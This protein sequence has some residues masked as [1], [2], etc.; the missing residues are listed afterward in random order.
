MI[1]LKNNVSY[2]NSW[3]YFSKGLIIKD[4]LKD[5]WSIIVV[6]EK[7]DYAR[8][9]S[10]IFSQLKINLSNIN[11]VSDLLNITKNK[12]WLYYLL[13]DDLD[14]VILNEYNILQSSL[15]VKI[16]QEISEESLIK[17]LND[18]WYSFNEYEKA[19][20]Y[21]KVWDLITIT[22]FSSN[23]LYKINFWGN[24]IEDIWIE[25][26]YEDIRLKQES[27]ENLI[28]WSNKNIYLEDNTE[29][30]NKKKKTWQQNTL[31]EF[32]KDSY[33]VLDYLDFYKNYERHINI[34]ENFSCFDVIWNKSLEIVDLKIN[35]LNI[36]CIEEFKELL[37]DRN[38]EKTIVTKNIKL[39][40]NFIKY[41]NLE[42]IKLEE[43]K[44]NNLKSFQLK[45]INQKPKTILC[46][47]IISKI[48]IKKR[49]NKKLSDNLDLLLKIKAWDFIVHIDHW[50]W[51]F[52]GIVKKQ[53]WD[54]TKEYAEILYKD[55]DK[56]FV[57]ITE[58]SRLSKYVWVDNPKLTPLNTKEWERKIK[59]VSE[60]V[61]IIAE[62][63]LETF[64]KRQNNKWFSFVHFPEKQQKFQS[65]FPYTYTEDQYKII[66]DII[67][68]MSLDKTMDR[69]LVWDVSFW[70]TEIAFN[71]I[72][73]CF[74][75]KKQSVLISPLVVLAYEHY[76]KALDR[77]RWLWMK[78]SVLTRL[79]SVKNTNE[80]LR[81]LREWKIDFI[82]WTHKLLSENTHFKDL[83]LLVI[84]EEHKFWVKDKEKIKKYKTKID[85]LSMSATPIPRSLNMALASI[86]DISILRNPPFWRKSIKTYVSKFSEN[87]IFE[88][89][90]KEFERWWQMFF[91]HNKVRNIDMFRE[92]LQ[93]IFPDK[94]VVITHGQLEW[95]ELEK[96]IIDFKH[97]KYD[98]LL[99]TTV[100]ENGV[101]FPNVNTIFIN[102]CENFGISQIH[103]LRWRVWRTTRQGYCYLMYKSEDI[104][105]EAAK[106]IK[107][108]VE[109]SY[110]WA[111]FE[112]AMKDLEIRGSGDILWI[113][114]SGQATLVWINLFI[115]M[116]EDKVEKLKKNKEYI[117]TDNM[118]IKIDLRLNAYLPDNFFL[119]ESD[120]LNFYREIESLNN[121]KDLD[122]LIEDFKKINDDFSEEVVNLFDMLRLK[123]KASKFA[124]SSIKKVWINYQIDFSEN[125]SLEK[126]KEFLNLDKEVKFTI[127]NVHKLRSS[128]KNFENDKSFLQY[129]LQLFSS[130]F[131]K[132]KRIK[133]K[134]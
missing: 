107:T 66:E 132:R 55:N 32:L 92:K 25:H 1:K 61:E 111:W 68:D 86:R 117:E 69:L 83:W 62:E 29:V 70:K 76:E 16:N 116:L 74:L 80:T 96:R 91:I 100:I 57:P 98:I 109:Y 48:F 51:V 39:I 77:F 114:Q 47:D 63:L 113:R 14:R 97:K 103:Q 17:K 110:L 87:M 22:D 125:I 129:L 73:N 53:L 88:A 119:N 38:L 81:D 58:S 20:T 127:I 101:D 6:V 64:A 71:A 12:K 133:L 124:I 5:K 121:E 28:I 44:V 26:K 9:F 30:S 122:N 41:N 89:W 108:I 118:D 90:K 2:I 128:I 35:E 65:L 15:E 36:K 67:Q 27:I 34:L 50:I 95:I 134:K 21:K 115:K 99:S 7:D 93:K 23:F 131:K 56:L 45:T 126:L 19:W 102:D 4:N 37:K 85:I 31:I 49:V 40:D 82:I 106:R 13:S 78:I 94:K 54:I 112:L 79:E 123:I 33:F 3:N 24:N 52:N 104:W 43:A 46:D 42:N 72:Y 105:T 18:L 130:D 60:D 10:S 75:N 84:D 120:K 59:K 8:F 11:T